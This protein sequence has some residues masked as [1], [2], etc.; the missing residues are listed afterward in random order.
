MPSTLLFYDDSYRIDHWNNEKERILLVTDKTL[1]ICKYDFIMLSCVQ[2]QQ[3]PLS[4]VYRICLG[5]FT[6]PGMS[7]DK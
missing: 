7:L 5:K 2:L 3:I 1:F 4:A 6:F